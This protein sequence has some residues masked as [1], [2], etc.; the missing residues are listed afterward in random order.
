MPSNNIIIGPT[1]RLLN[2]AP[3]DGSV[4]GQQIGQFA[5]TAAARRLAVTYQRDGQRCYDE[6]MLCVANSVIM[7]IR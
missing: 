7:S 5:V 1:I 4:G 3:C 6:G 2:L